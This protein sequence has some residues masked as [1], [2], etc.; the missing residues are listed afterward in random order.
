MVTFY[1]KLKYNQ[2]KLK[3]HILISA[4]FYKINKEDQRGDETE[5]F[6]NLNNNNNLTES[7]FNNI[8]VISQ[9]DSNLR[10]KGVWLDF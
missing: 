10:K 9:L 6:I 1:A 5:L 4:T 3:Y 8:D 2:Y 7:D